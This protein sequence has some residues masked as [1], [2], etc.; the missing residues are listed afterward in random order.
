MLSG[1]WGPL[2]FTIAAIAAAGRAPN[3]SHRRHHISGLAAQRMPSAPIM[4]PGFMAYGIAGLM[5]PV[6]DRLVQRLVRLAGGATLGAGLARCSSVECPT[7]M[8]NEGVTTSD[9]AHAAASIVAFNTWTLLPTITAVRP[10]PR[11]Y[12]RAS[13]PLAALTWIAYLVNST[14]VRS[15]SARRG[16]TQRLFL[17]PVLTWYVLTSVRAIQDQNRCACDAPS[18]SL[19]RSRR[20][21]IRLG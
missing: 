12:R 8:I 5:Q 20:N 15:Q 18:G 4:V 16:L 6:D 13:A 1:V 14:A 3:Y 17:A 11:W 21:V 2:A 9:V 7:P 10:G 19:R